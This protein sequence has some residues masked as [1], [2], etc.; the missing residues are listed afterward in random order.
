MANE[1]EDMKITGN[2]RKLTDFIIADIL[3]DPSNA[4]LDIA[5]LETNLTA[6]IG[7]VEDIGVKLAPSKLAI[8]ARQTAYP[9]A[10]SVVRGSRNI[11]KASGTSAQTLEDANTFTFS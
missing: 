6:S 2:F 1:T 4:V 10:I 7:S 3:Y 9:D 8:N 11:L 5:N